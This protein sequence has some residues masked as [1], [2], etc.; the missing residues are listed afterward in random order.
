MTTIMLPFPSSSRPAATTRSTRTHLDAHGRVF[1]VKACPL[2]AGAHPLSKQVC[3]VQMR[4]KNDELAAF[5]LWGCRS[6]WAPKQVVSSLSADLCKLGLLPCKLGRDA[7]PDAP[8]PPSACARTLADGIWPLGDDS[9][10]DVSSW[11]S[12]RKLRACASC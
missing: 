2:V 12:L 3:A 7:Q 4:T 8:A 11:A 6:S 5:L 10:R 1:H 9:S